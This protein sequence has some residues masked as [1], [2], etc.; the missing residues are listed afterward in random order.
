M[1]GVADLPAALLRAERRGLALAPLD[2][3]LEPG[4][5]DG[6]RLQRLLLQR[7]LAGGEALRGWKV[8]LCGAAAQARFGL[9]EPVYGA[10][11][12]A[13]ELPVDE[14]IGLGRFIQPKLEIELAYRLARGLA[15][16]RYDDQQLL[17]AIAEVAPAFEVADCRWRGWRFG[18]GAFLADNA[19][20]AGYC[21]GAFQAFDAHR[22]AQV[23]YR[24]TRDGAGLGAGCA[25]CEPMGHL[26][27]LLR[28]LLD[29]GQPLHAGQVVLSGALLAPLDIV[30]GDYSLEMLGQRLLVSFVAP[31]A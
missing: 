24:L 1:S 10:L 27:W 14:R 8:A 31:A 29:D 15:P 22:H 3:G 26:L 13:M 7:R 23:T 21:L 2:G 28:R 20:A 30:A 6:Y 5:A 11:T 4:K 19:A 16:G 17:R 25:G 9:D 18:L 12:S